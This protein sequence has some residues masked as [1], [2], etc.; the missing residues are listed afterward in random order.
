MLDK[1]IG[2]AIMAVF[3]APIDLERHADKA[4]HA[5]LKMY[6]TVEELSK[7]FQSE[8]LPSVKIGVGV[9]TGEAT[10]GN[11]GS[12][13]RFDYTAIGDCVNLA[14]RLESLNKYYKTH[15]LISETTK[16]SL[17]KSSL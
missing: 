4:C 2:D 13:V 8:G 3:N 6:K 10:V 15:I 17:Q 14:S 12:D 9:N 16:M 7:K 5:A 1:Y 11:I